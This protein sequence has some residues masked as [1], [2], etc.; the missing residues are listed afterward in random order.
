MSQPESAPSASPLHSQATPSYQANGCRW[1]WCGQIFSTTE[2]LL[3]HVIHAHVRRATPVRRGDIPMLR[4]AEEGIGSSFNFSA[5]AGSTQSNDD[6]FKVS[7]TSKEDAM[8]ICTQEPSSSLPS[9]PASSPP[10]LVHAY[11]PEPKGTRFSSSASDVYSY[12]YDYERRS[13]EQFQGQASG[14]PAQPLETIY[15]TSSSNE[16]GISGRIRSPVPIISRRAPTFS[17]L[18]GNADSPPS[19]TTPASPTLEALVADAIRSKKRKTHPDIDADVPSL[20]RKIPESDDS[21][22]GQY[23]QILQSSY[24]SHDSVEKQLTQ[25]LNDDL[26]GRSNLLA[27]LKQPDN[28]DQATT[29]LHVDTSTD[30][31]VQ[32][33]GDGDCTSLCGSQ[34]P[35]LLQRASIHLPSQLSQLPSQFQIDPQSHASGSGTQS[36][37]LSIQTQFASS[38]RFQLTPMP[39]PSPAFAVSTPFMARPQQAWYQPSVPIHRVSRKKSST[40]D[41]QSV[42]ANASPASEAKMDSDDLS[43]YRFGAL[44]LQPTMP[45]VNGT[46]LQSQKQQSPSQSSP[47]RMRNHATYSHSQLQSQADQLQESQWSHSLDGSQDLSYPAL[48]TQAPYQSQSLS[49]M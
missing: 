20:R 32:S 9:P 45:S 30:A 29:D 24:D 34:S 37:S 2:E 10:S 26:K 48:Q 42:S 40:G 36:L 7:A 31:V 15:I 27:G 41:A 23:S 33:P 43:A 1:N 6:T 21:I 22:N 38:P 13:P 16:G 19:Q 4:R 18:V 3:H 17:S 14:Q 25:S 39:L 35:I 28:G 46:P 44:N 11:S 12:A 49:Q 5:I 47:E 8:P